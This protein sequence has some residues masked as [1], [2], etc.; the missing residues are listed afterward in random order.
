MEILD[1]FLE[2]KYQKKRAIIIAIFVAVFLL[3]VFLLYSWLKPAPSCFDEKKN[4]NET[5]VDCGGVCAIKCAIVAQDLTS[6]E[7]GFVES[8][9]AGKL[10][11]YARVSNPNSTFGSKKFQ[12]EFKLF[13]SA[14]SVVATK[15]GVSYILPAESKYVVENNVEINGVPSR[16]EFNILDRDWSEFVDYY[17]RPQLK[18]VNKTYGQINSGIGFSEAK[19]LLKNE[20][21]FNFNTIR[22][23]IILKDANDSVIALNSTEMNTVKSGENRDFRALWLNRFPGEVMNVEVQAGVNIFESDT[24]IKQY[25]VPGKYKP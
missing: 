9:I 18:I 13:D 2:D 23:D 19:G 16:I 17:E 10:D 25:F 6:Q 5:G 3:F 15:K 12:Y 11:L 4:Q 14:G 7:S 8:G 21:V 1:K 22:L 24:F 20:S